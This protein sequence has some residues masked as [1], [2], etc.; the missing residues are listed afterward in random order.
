MYFLI[1]S[2]V[3]TFFFFL[4]INWTLA[5]VSENS[6]GIIS[7]APRHRERNI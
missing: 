6:Q 7:L 4:T 1:L 2:R 5:K 3:L